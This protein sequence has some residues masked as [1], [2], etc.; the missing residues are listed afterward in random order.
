MATMPGIRELEVYTRVDWV[1]SLPWARADHMQRNKVA[2]D[3]PAA[4]TLALNSPAR[5]AMRKDYNNFPPFAGKVTHFP[6]ATL[7][8]RP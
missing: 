8:I 4:L 1:G 7:V 2:F 3:S 5:A 6:M